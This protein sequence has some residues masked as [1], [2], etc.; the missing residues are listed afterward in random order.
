VQDAAVTVAIRD[1]RL[2]AEQSAQR[3][4]AQPRDSRVSVMSSPNL[5]L[6]I[7]LH[8]LE[9]EW[10]RV[11]EASILARGNYQLLAARNAGADVLDAAKERLDRADALKA[12][13]AAKIEWLE[14]SLLRQGA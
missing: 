14:A 4:G 5:D 12:R 6:D 7:E 2:V 8:Q 11:Y 13:V 10:R 3:S 1:R 9:R